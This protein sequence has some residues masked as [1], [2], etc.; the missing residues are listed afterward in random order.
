MKYGQR[1]EAEG[2]WVVLEIATGKDVW[3]MNGGATQ[4]ELRNERNWEPEKRDAKSN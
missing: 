4:T 2:R 1:R 3:I